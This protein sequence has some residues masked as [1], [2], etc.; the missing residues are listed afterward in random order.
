MTFDPN[1]R[2]GCSGVCG[3]DNSR[4]GAIHA[5]CNIS[6]TKI[7]KT[8]YNRSNERAY[9]SACVGA[10]GILMKVDLKKRQFED[11]FFHFYFSNGDILLHNEL[12]EI[13]FYPDVHNIHME[14]TVSQIFYSGHSSDFI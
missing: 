12:S 4:R 7:A 14:G 6:R 10:N 2:S 3:I 9:F 13:T 11:L 1:V 5:L 8:S